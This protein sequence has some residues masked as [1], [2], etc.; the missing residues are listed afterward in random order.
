MNILEEIVAHKRE[1][2]KDTKTK[3]KISLYESGVNPSPN[4]RS[5]SSSIKNSPCGIIS[6]FKRRSPSK[7]QIN[8]D[9]KVSDVVKSYEINGAS[10]VSILTNEKY[11]GGLKEDIQEARIII[12]LPI[13]RKEFIVDKFQIL[14]AA[15]LGADAILLIASVLN[16][17]EINELSQY[18]HQ[19]GLEVLL[20]IHDEKE[21]DK[22]NNTVDVIGVNNRN[23]K[24]FKT[25]F[26]HSI[27]LYPYL[28]KD[29]VLISESGLSHSDQL[30]E[31]LDCGYNGFLI[32]ES[33]MR[34]NLP[35]QALNELI[36]TVIY[37]R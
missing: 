27:N 33:F 12:D 9:A 2:L 37:E 21:I 24:E 11:F 32:G 7:P 23:L 26:K 4:R 15:Y 14:E 8:L 31:L 28:P 30:I 13:L 6:E 19:L 22:I 20:E 29:K 36:K 10:A 16:K 35:G 1:D 34:H 3:E 25:D 18:A 17:S 5:F